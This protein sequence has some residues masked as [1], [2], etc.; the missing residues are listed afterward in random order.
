MYAKNE[1]EREN[2]SGFRSENSSY[3]QYNTAHSTNKIYQIFCLQ[4]VWNEFRKMRNEFKECLKFMRFL[5]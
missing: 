2:L 3:L 1:N 5:S 4:N